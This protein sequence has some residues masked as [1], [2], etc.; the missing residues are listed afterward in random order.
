MTSRTVLGCVVLLFSAL[1]A[2]AWDPV[3]DLTGKR[4]DQHLDRAVQDVQN[5]PESWSRCLGNPR[6]CSEDLLRRIPYSAVWPI[7]D[8]YKAHLFNQAQGR[9]QTIP[10]GLLEMVQ[11]EYSVDLRAIRYATNI[12]TVHG[13][14]ITWENSIFFP[15]AIN[16]D[17]NGDLHWL[18]HEIE[19]AVQYQRRGGFRELF[20][21]YILKSMGKVIE[22]QSINPHDYVD[23]ERAAE[24][25][26]D[27]ALSVVLAIESRERDGGGNQY[28]GGSYGGSAQNGYARP[29][30]ACYTA[31]GVCPMAIAVAIGSQCVCNTGYGPVWGLAQ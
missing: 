12:D 8:R 3:R 21:E 7:M 24:R 29:A 28:G 31:I 15:R 17:D 14:A 23:I 25:K 22:E 11:S 2:V 16:L 19:H 1:S 5:A 4:L 6:Q 10:S 27:H 26:A 20:G 18:L 9:W 13:Q 30:A